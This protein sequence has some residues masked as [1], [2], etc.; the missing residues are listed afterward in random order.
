[1]IKVIE[2]DWPAPGNVRAFCTTRGGGYSEG[3]YT[4]L[5]LADHVGDS[6]ASVSRNRAL[7]ADMFAT[8]TSFQWLRQVHGTNVVQAPEAGAPEADAVWTERQGVAIA[9]LTADCLPV[10]FC[11]REGTLVAAAHAGWRGLAAGVLEATLEALP[12]APQEL[13]A[14]LGPAIGASAFEVGPEVRTAFLSAGGSRAGLSE[15]ETAAAFQPSPAQ[16]G[17]FLADLNHLARQR[18]KAA[19]VT[20]IYAGEHCTYVESD[21]FFSHRRD[22][23]TGRMASLICINGT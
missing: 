3:A 6:P 12:A 1:M 2:P 18:L 9:V 7:L 13:M 4:S 22:G 14:W 11:N 19:G 21:Q 23:Q 8:G 20:Q 5:N 15:R 17:H 10:L 16:P